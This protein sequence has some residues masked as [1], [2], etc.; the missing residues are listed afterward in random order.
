MLILSGQLGIEVQAFNWLYLALLIYIF[1][2]NLLKIQLRYCT[3]KV[4]LNLKLPLDA[5]PLLKEEEIADRMG[6]VSLLLFLFLN[7]DG[8]SSEH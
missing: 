5:L 6:T 1:I 2:Y 3:I 7:K 4:S 8:T